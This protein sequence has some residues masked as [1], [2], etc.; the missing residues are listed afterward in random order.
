MITTA[1]QTAPPATAPP[2]NHVYHTTIKPRLLEDLYEEEQ[3]FIVDYLNRTVFAQDQRSIT[4]DDLSHELKDG[5][6]LCKL[7]NSI[8]PGTIKNIKQKDLSF[9]KMD[10]IVRFLQGARQLGLDN[11]RLFETADLF[12]GKNMTA[13]L[14]TILELAKLGCPDNA[15]SPLGFIPS[16]LDKEHSAIFKEEKELTHQGQDEA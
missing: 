2:V 1:G 16:S 11:D 6:A 9:V 10:N 5:I 8:R 7:V 14:R 3:Q 15:A 13:V 12:E 4:F